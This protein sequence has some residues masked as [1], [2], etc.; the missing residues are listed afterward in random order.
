MTRQ[1]ALPFALVLALVG[2]GVTSTSSSGIS[3]P[4][5]ASLDEFELRDRC[6]PKDPTEDCTD[7]ALEIAEAM[8][9][10]LGQPQPPEDLRAAV[11]GPHF[12][13][14]VDRDPPWDW[15]S[16]DG[17]TGTTPTATIDLVPCFVSGDGAIVRLDVDAPGYVVPL[18]LT[19]RLVDALFVRG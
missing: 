3:V 7:R 13:I 14:Q 8:L 15:R 18:D 2:C 4:S 5:G 10:R 9:Q 19:Q 16:A 1:G 11:A 12:D 6:N 17:S